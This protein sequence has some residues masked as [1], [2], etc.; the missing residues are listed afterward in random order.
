V[1]NQEGLYA[2]GVEAQGRG[3]D[4]SFYPQ[5]SPDPT[6]FVARLVAALRR[7]LVNLSFLMGRWKPQPAPGPNE[8]GGAR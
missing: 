6:T 1:N 8:Q 2:G 4:T 3:G 5:K 7:W